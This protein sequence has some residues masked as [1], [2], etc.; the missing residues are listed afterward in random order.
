MALNPFDL[1]LFKS[2]SVPLF[3]DC[4]SIAVAVVPSFPFTAH[5]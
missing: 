4:F 3:L 5:K 1:A 2:S